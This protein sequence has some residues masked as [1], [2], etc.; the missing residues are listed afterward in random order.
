MIG[1]QEEE[2]KEKED[3]E[4]GVENPVYCWKTKK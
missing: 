2:D 3:E 4:Q 1:G